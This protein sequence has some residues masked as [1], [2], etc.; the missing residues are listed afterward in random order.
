M[1]MGMGE[2]EFG[3]RSGEGV[4]ARVFVCTQSPLTS[5]ST[6]QNNHNIQPYTH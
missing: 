1:W 6:M 5:Y 2:G 3:N 4:R